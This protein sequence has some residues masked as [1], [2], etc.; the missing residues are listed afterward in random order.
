[1]EC[2]QLRAEFLQGRV[3]AEKLLVSHERREGGEATL[4]PLFFA[5]SQIAYAQ[6]SIPNSFLFACLIPDIPSTSEE[7]D[8]QGLHELDPPI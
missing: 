7:N 2:D 8:V 1:M 5:P 6:L 3:V 4:H